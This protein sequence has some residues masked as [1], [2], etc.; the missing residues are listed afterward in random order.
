MAILSTKR[1]TYHLY[2]YPFESPHSKYLLL[3]TALA[4][5]RWK[6]ILSPTVSVHHILLKKSCDVAS[7]G[8]A[9][10]VDSRS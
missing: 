6:L 4:I 1:I 5:F 7:M 2:A 8:T 3:Q 9:F 10:T